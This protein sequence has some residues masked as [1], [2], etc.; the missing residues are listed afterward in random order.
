MHIQYAWDETKR[1]SNL[2]IHGLDFADVNRVFSNFTFTFE[3]M[4][5]DYHEQRFVSLGLLDGLVVAIVHTETADTV[6]IISL[7]KASKREQTICFTQVQN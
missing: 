2:K 1:Q 3:D 6:R 7:R 4:R 5:F